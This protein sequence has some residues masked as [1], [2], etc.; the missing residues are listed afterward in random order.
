M[1]VFIQQNDTTYFE[2]KMFVILIDESIK[3]Q[4]SANEEV[5]VLLSGGIDSTTI[6]AKASKIKSKLKTFSFG[7][8]ENQS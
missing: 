6:V 1:Q 2:A 7:F 3:R 5:G 4:I 8:K